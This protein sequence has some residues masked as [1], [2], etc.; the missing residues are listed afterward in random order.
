MTMLPMKTS[1]GMVSPGA[2]GMTQQ[3]M[4]LL[5]LG[6]GLLSGNPRTQGLASGLQAYG[7]AYSPQAA[8]QRQMM[9]AQTE[10]LQRK[11]ARDKAYENLILGIPTGG[12]AAQAAQP[13]MVEPALGGSL[14]DMPGGGVEPGQVQTAMMPPPQAAGSLRLPEGVTPEM[15]L[16]L[17]PDRGAAFLAQMYKPKTPTTVSPG[18]S[19]I[20]PYTGNVIYTAPFKPTGAQSDIA[21]L[22][23][24]LAEGRISQA[25]FDR[26]L[27]I[28]SKPLVAMPGAETEESKAVGKWYGE[29]Y[30][31]LQD[32]A[33][34]ARRQKSNLQAIDTLLENVYTGKGG[35]A[36]L[37]G[38]KLARLIGADPEGI[39]SAEAAQALANE[40]ALQLR[41]PAGGAGMPGAM[42]DRD[43]DFLQSMIPGLGTTKEGRKLIIETRNRIA[44]RDIE[45]AAMARDYRREKGRLDEGFYDRLDA[46]FRDSDMFSDLRQSKVP[47]IDLDQRLRDDPSSLTDEE[48][49]KLAQ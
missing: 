8:M 14:V 34:S 6:I 23:Q 25:D 37:A 38:K 15:M 19:V 48:L 41:N 7:Q 21:K 10:E 49:R 31:A 17:G 24:D 35:E 40:Q 3:Q 45:V 33:S 28:K 47:A 20:N 32:A 22:R 13:S 44:D 29:K 27:A 36:I 2:G 46:K 18:S 16:A 43:R 9:Q 42:S 11:A 26:A 12:A 1:P 5:G 30:T 4:G 39:G